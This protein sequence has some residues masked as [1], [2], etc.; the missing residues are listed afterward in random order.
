MGTGKFRIMRGPTGLDRLP[1]SGARSRRA[2]EPVLKCNPLSPPKNRDTCGQ[3]VK[4]VPERFVKDV[5]EL[6]SFSSAASAYR[7]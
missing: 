2:P 3:S 7:K 1:D 5:M 4:D 6:D